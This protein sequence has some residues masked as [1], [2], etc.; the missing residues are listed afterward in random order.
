MPPRSQFNRVS[1]ERTLSLT[2][3]ETLVQEPE[4]RSLFD[5]VVEVPPDPVV[6]LAVD[7]VVVIPPAAEL[8]PTETQPEDVQGQ[9]EAVVET[10]VQKKTVN[11]PLPRF[12]H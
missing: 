1:V 9:G 8:E 7:A 5:P 6:P 12:N 4:D 3:T 10:P 2:E 11:W